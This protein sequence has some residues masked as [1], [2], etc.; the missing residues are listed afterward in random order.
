MSPTAIRKQLHDLI[1]QYPEEELE[2]LLELI[3]GSERQTSVLDDPEVLAEMNRR[4]EAYQNG[5]ER[6][7]T[8]EESRERINRI[9][10]RK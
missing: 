9:I 4:W 7:F 2:E 3:R 5:T 8:A 10:N 1:D 6:A